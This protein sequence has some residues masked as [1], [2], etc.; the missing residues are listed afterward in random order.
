LSEIAR[1]LP[2]L[3]ELELVFTGFHITS[4]GFQRIGAE[5][6]QQLNHLESFSLQFREYSFMKKKV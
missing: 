3:K 1:H 2:K 4:Q 5:I 6:S